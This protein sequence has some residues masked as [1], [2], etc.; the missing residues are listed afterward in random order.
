MVP[1]Y[2]IP[3]YLQFCICGLNQPLS[4]CTIV[5]TT[6]KNLYTWT[7]AVQTCFVQGSAVHSHLVFITTLLEISF[8][9][10]YRGGCGVSINYQWFFQGNSEKVRNQTQATLWV[11]CSFYFTSGAGSSTK[12]RAVQ[13]GA[14]RE[15]VR[16]HGVHAQVHNS[17]SCCHLRHLWGAVL[18]KRQG[19][20]RLLGDPVK[21]QILISG[22]WDSA[23]LI[24]SQII[25]VLL[26]EEPYFE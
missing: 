14:L 11:Q 2:T 20:Y 18:L 1:L 24:N 26:V 19:M 23:F 17:N 8:P 15:L 25:P 13:S 3:P 21:M 6:E 4:C 12:G 22:A 10:F 5:F 16:A 7:C 9:P